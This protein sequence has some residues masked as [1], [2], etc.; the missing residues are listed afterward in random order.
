[1]LEK[2]FTSKTRVKILTLFMM[3][4]QKE[5]FV[6]EISRA[7]NENINS[8]RRELSNLEE[9]GLLISTKKGNMKYYILRKDF[10]IYEEL[11]NIILKTEGV[12]KI[13]KD[14]LNEIGEINYAFIYG[15]FA[16]GDANPMSDIDVF[17]IGDIDEDQ[18][19]KEVLEIEQIL[20]REI[21]YI[22]FSKK[23]FEQRIQAND[24]FILNV[25]K[26]PKIMII[27]DLNAEEA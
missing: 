23:E 5:M 22:S 15:S 2:L 27:G 7:T 4:P 25:L 24:P 11:K 9:I 26:E 1:M 10:P 14:N 19:I 3:N 12:S 6:R 17:L 13:I 18:L 21:N 8:V 16:S 20:S